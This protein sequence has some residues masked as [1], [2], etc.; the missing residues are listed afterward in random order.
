MKYVT[1]SVPVNE[2]QVLS[3][4]KAHDI[5]VVSAVTKVATQNM[6]SGYG[7]INNASLV[8]VTHAIEAVDKPA[9]VKLS[10]QQFID[11]YKPLSSVKYSLNED[12]TREDRIL[13]YYRIGTKR[14]GAKLLDQRTL[15]P[16][17][18][19][20]SHLWV[21][22]AERVDND[23]VVTLRP[24]IVGSVTFTKDQDLQGYVVTTELHNDKNIIITISTQ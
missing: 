19:I 12:V 23:V 4:M 3:M 6:K 22:V 8:E 10:L 24:Y 21:I 13:D 11:K 9:V 1:V 2:D 20:E 17:L 16:S 14:D 5:T 18:K 15:L 7:K